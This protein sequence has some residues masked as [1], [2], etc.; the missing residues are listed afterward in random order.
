[1]SLKKIGQDPRVPPLRK[2]SCGKAEGIGLVTEKGE[3]NMGLHKV[4]F[5]CTVSSILN[6]FLNT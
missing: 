3:R 6:T 5:F 4:L 2:K 1:M